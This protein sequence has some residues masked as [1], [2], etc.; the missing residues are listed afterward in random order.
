MYLVLVVIQEGDMIKE[1][2]WVNTDNTPVPK[3]KAQR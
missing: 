2:N 3:R 1:K